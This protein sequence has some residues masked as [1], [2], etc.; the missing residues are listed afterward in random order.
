MRDAHAAGVDVERVADPPR[1]LQ[2]RVPA[3]Q[4]RRPLTEE[5]L[6]RFAAELGEE[7]VVVGARRAVEEEQGHAVE[8][9][10]DDRR[11]RA[12]LLD[13]RRVELGERPDFRAVAAAG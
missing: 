2:V 13:L 8:L 3:R 11:E 1:P 12:D 5:R 9:A 4:Q 6:D 10:A 7:D